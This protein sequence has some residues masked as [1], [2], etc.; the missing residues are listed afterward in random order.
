MLFKKDTQN[1][2]FRGRIERHDAT[3]DRLIEAGYTGH[4]AAPINQLHRW[5]LHF[6]VF[7]S[8]STRENSDREAVDH[9]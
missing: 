8:L 9:G 2:H 5:V 6:G 1:E 7:L 3:L 4:D